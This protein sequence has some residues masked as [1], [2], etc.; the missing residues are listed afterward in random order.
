M[1]LGMS[2]LT[3]IFVGLLFVLS[4]ALIVTNPVGMWSIPLGILVLL[5][6]F[7]VFSRVPKRG[8]PPAQPLPE[9]APLT[10]PPTLPLAPPP[11]RP[12]IRGRDASEV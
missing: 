8:R 7:A 5:I 10:E 1:F 11:P 9:N 12:T 2:R 4:L 3:W 6:A